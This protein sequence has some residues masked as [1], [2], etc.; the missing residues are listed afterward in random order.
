MKAV[1]RAVASLINRHPAFVVVIL[2]AL[3]LVACL[4]ATGAKTSTGSD[5][6]MDKDTH[7]GVIMDKYEDLFE[8]ESITLIVESSDVTHPDMLGY[9]WDLEEDIRNEP[10]VTVVSGL[11]DTLKALNGGKVPASLAESR[12]AVDA[13]PTSQPLNTR[14]MA[15]IHRA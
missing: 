10:Y 11:V 4:G 12:N 7:T 9:M 8:A 3:F 15:L 6:Y 5:T 13:M 1:Y 14:M 2:A